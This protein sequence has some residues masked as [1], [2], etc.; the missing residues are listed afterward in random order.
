MKRYGL[1]ARFLIIILVISALIFV[2]GC[3]LGEG[4]TE[5]EELKNKIAELEEELEKSESKPTLEAEE[6]T[7]E[8]ETQES[9]EEETQG[10]SVEALKDKVCLIDTALGDFTKFQSMLFEKEMDLIKEFEPAG[11]NSISLAILFKPNDARI[12]KLY[13]YIN[14]GGKAVCYYDNNTTRYN[15]TFDNFFG[16][17]I[18]NEVVYEDNTNSITLDGKLF[19]DFTEDLKIAFIKQIVTTMKINSYIIYIFVT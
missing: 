1:V 9:I 11:Y 6:S 2:T 17:S 4:S 7:V 13:D 14:N 18:T 8:E 19:S 10:S 15:D 16:V 3:K 12:T 5:V